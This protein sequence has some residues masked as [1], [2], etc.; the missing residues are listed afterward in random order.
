M[1]KI[2][3]TEQIAVTAVKELEIKYIIAALSTILLAKD[4]SSS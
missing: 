1:K 2:E 4:N 3:N